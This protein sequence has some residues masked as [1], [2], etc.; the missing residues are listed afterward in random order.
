MEQRESARRELDRQRQQ[1]AE[2]HK[3]VE[4][5]AQRQREQESVCH[6]KQKQKNLTFQMQAMQEKST[7]ISA[8]ITQIRAKIVGMTNSIEG[9]KKTRDGKV[10]D[11]DRVKRE[12]LD[13]QSKFAQLLR[14]RQELQNRQMQIGDGTKVSETF[15][16]VMHG[17]HNH[18]L[19]ME[20]L[21]QSLTETEKE[22]RAKLEARE[23]QQT[24]MDSAENEIQI[25][26][27][28]KEELIRTIA[29]KQM[30]A[31]ALFENNAAEKQRAWASQGKATQ[32]Q[33]RGSQDAWGGSDGVAAASQG[34]EDNWA[35][36]PGAG[37]A[38]EQSANAVRYR[39]VFEFQARSDDEISFQPGDT[40]MVFT[41][42]SAQPGWLA[43]EFQG[44]VGWFPSD[45]A[46][47]V[48]GGAATANGGETWSAPV[49]HP[50]ATYAGGTVE[51]LDGIQEHTYEEEHHPEQTV[52][53]PK[54]QSPVGNGN[55]FGLCSF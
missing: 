42:H 4:L 27:R 24:R 29:E 45:Y 3:L 40:I 36:Q 16:Q 7:E 25:L 19:N 21:R 32:S 22:I 5:I 12:L 11:L 44:K 33:S 50:V 23:D 9:M 39:A 28:D 46:E 35:A 54:V 37:G 20:S 30:E 8:Q 38:V 18:E 52:A 41:D 48:D 10:G 51:V 17:M 15:R 13:A 2:K 49:T 1:E 34:F 6:L 47:P 53:K 26:K 14:E 43:G 55:G 31:R